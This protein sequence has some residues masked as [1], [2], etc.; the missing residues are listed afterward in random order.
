MKKYFIFLNIFIYLFLKVKSTF[1]LS[2]KLIA[3]DD[4][5]YRIFNYKNETIYPKSSSNSN[6]PIVP[7]MPYELGEKIF[8]DLYD[9]GKGN[10][11]V[12]LTVYLNEYTIYTEYQKFWTCTNCEGANNNYIYN[13]SKKRLDFYTPGKT[14]GKT[15]DLHYYFYFQINSYSEL[16]YEG[17]A[18]QTN[19]YSFTEEKYFFIH[20]SNL[21]EEIDIINFNTTDIFYMVN[22]RDLKTPFDVIKF[23]I[24]FD[25]LISFSGKFIGFD[26]SKNDIE[27]EDQN[28]FEVSENKGLRYKL[29]PKEKNRKGVY[30]KIKIQAYNSP[31]G[32]RLPQILSQISEFNFFICL[33]GHQFCDIMLSLN[34][35]NKGYYKNALDNRYY[36]CYDTCGSCETYYK[37][38]NA[39]Y[40]KHYCDTCNTKY[41][42]FINIIEQEGENNSILKYKNCYEKCPISAPYLKYL[43]SK[44]CTPSCPKYRT[45]ENI[46]VDFC[47]AN[48]YKYLLDD[49]KICYNYIPNNY[50]IYIDNYDEKYN[51]SDNPIIKLGMKCPDNYS[52]DSNFKNICI[53]L[54]KDIFYLISTNELITY[55]NPQILWLNGKS[56]LLRTYTTNLNKTELTKIDKQYSFVDIS[57]CEKSLKKFYNISEDKALLIYDIKDLT[58]NEIEYKIY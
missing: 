23:K 21:E 33:T 36:S 30:L 4:S 48:K 56:I 39:N 5:V 16:N 10:G 24:F 53:N 58:N 9:V 49:E 6:D 19:F 2:M 51:E 3:I 18:L 26:E 46:C 17:N 54:I 52:N 35:L 57:Q 50:Y 41:P 15:L 55:N 25:E 31:S 29:S 14:K 1:Y 42:Y 40:N 27:L 45:N 34:C 8:F 13:K 44:E 37:P 32:E 43:N 28:L 20:I 22:N 12:S 11:G 47:D 7:L 38:E